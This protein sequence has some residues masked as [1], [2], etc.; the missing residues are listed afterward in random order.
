MGINLITFVCE[1]GM[2]YEY[3][4]YPADN[5]LPLNKYLQEIKAVNGRSI[6]KNLQL[7]LE[8]AF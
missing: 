5:F 6:F 4:L 3:G 7:H 2:H 1:R 8:R